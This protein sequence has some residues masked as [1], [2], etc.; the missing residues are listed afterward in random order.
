MLKRRR[1]RGFLSNPFK[2]K[3]STGPE[4]TTFKFSSTGKI[5][6]LKEKNGEL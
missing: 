2:P 4:L 1:K 3:V 6:D 5:G